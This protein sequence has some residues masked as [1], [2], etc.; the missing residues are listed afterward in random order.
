MHPSLRVLLPAVLCALVV[1]SCGRPEPAPTTALEPVPVSIEGMPDARKVGD[2]LLGGQPDRAAIDRL[3]AAGYRTVVSTRGRGELEWDEAA[4]IRAAG[5]DYVFIPMD[6]PVQAITD[7]TLDALDRVMREA[8]RP[9]VLHCSTGN[10]T[11]G[12]WA[13]WLAEREGVAP[14]EA[15][16]LG[17]AAGL[18]RLAPVVEKRLLQTSTPPSAER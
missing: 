13:V 8:E 6:K 5:M 10:R 3:A 16:R 15:L 17:K 9:L 7:E 4:A 14:E 2:I 18:T 12:L 11:A 1:P